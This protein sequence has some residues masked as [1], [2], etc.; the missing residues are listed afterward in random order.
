MIGSIAQMDEVRQLVVDLTRIGAE[1]EDDAHAASR[2]G[3]A[4]SPKISLRMLRRA[5]A[6]AA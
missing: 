4:V 5:F 1:G 3:T 6:N 2:A